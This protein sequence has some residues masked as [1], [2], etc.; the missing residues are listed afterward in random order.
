MSPDSRP[1][2]GPVR[3]AA[4]D[5]APAVPDD[6]RR[7]VPRSLEEACALRD[8]HRLA[9]P[10]A[11]ATA[12]LLG[13]PEGRAPGPLLD[14]GMLVRAARRA[15]PARHVEGPNGAPALVLSAF[16]PLERLRVDPQV[17]AALP[18][19]AALLKDLGSAPVRRL[20]TLGGNLCWP[21]GDLG[22]VMLAL[23][24]VFRFHRSGAM[25]ACAAD[26]MP[27][28]ELLLE[29]RVPCAPH[30]TVLEKVGHRA[31]FSPT[32]V[33]VALTDAPDGLRIAVGGG[34]TAARRLFR[35]EALFDGGAVPTVRSVRDA[36]AAEM[37]TR[38]DPLVEGAA[39]IDVAARTIAGHLAHWGR[40][41]GAQAGR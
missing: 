37:V 11:G 27:A 38:D 15:V 30:R 13:W 20:G 2:S 16:T 28:G 21:A 7:F 24:A 8:A 41:A 3:A 25:P 4:I 12:A 39:R 23:G 6:V 14:L 1:V 29:V 22:P 34:V 10:L 36:V 40:C 17:R 5:A 26:A 18:A 35:T 9:L 32:L 33:T 19:L 31:A